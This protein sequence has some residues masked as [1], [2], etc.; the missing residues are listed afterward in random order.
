M[1]GCICHFVADTPFHIQGFNQLSIYLSY[2]YNFYLFTWFETYTCILTLNMLIGTIVVFCLFY[3]LTKS[4]LSGV[5]W[6]FKHTNLQ[7][8][9]ISVMFTHLKL[10]VAVG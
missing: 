6:M 9:P 5:K 7:I 8:Q 3:L 10:W 1:K 4:M 2:F